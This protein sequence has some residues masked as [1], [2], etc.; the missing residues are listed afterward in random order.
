MSYIPVISGFI[1][2]KA[3]FV[4]NCPFCG[5][6]HAHSNKGYKVGDFVFC[7]ATCTEPRYVILI[8][9]TVKLME[10]QRLSRRKNPSET[11]DPILYY[12]DPQEGVISRFKPEVGA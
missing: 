11:R 2:K 5:C 4:K 8:V 12:L 9:G 7:D 1:N 10:L 6:S 3:V